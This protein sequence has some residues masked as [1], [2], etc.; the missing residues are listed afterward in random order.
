MYAFNYRIVE[1][2]RKLDKYKILPTKDSMPSKDRILP[3]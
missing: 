2:N 3:K 1:K